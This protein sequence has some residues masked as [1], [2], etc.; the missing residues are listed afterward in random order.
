MT[1]EDIQDILKRPTSPRTDL[2]HAIRL[3]LLSQ[4]SL[5]ETRIDVLFAMYIE[6]ASG[7]IWEKGG[8]VNIA[9]SKRSDRVMQK[10]FFKGV[11]SGTAEYA[12]RQFQLDNLDLLAMETCFTPERRIHVARLVGSFTEESVP[13]F[14]V[15]EDAEDS[16]RLGAIEA[17][18]YCVRALNEPETMKRMIGASML[19]GRMLKQI[20]ELGRNDVERNR[21]ALEGAGL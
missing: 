19:A 13:A 12:R 2:D 14:N 3:A 16:F 4:P 17:M 9:R 7:Y 8:L 1:K 21:Q 15:P 10:E 5:F 11:E 18:G 20:E 6:H